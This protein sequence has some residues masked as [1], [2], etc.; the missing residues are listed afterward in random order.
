MTRTLLTAIFLTLCSQTAWASE[1][2]QLPTEMCKGIYEG[3][4]TSMARWRF[5]RETLAPHK[6][7]CDDNTAL[8]ELCQ[9]QFLDNLVTK[10]VEAVEQ[11]AKLAEIYRTFCK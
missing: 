11:A 9:Q 6:K 3:V 5:L 8:T 10:K 4:L 2:H 1:K 7:K